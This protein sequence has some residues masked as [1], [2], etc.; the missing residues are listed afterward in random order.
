MADKLNTTIFTKITDT[1]KEI[2]AT[3]NDIKTNVINKAISFETEILNWFFPKNRLRALTSELPMRQTAALSVVEIKDAL[4][5]IKSNLNE[6]K[7]ILKSL[8]IVSQVQTAFNKYNSVIANGL[9]VLRNPINQVINQIK[10]LLDVAFINRV[11]QRIDETLE[12]VKDISLACVTQIKFDVEEVVQYFK[13][14]PSV[15]FDELNDAL[16]NQIDAG[17]NRL[18]AKVLSKVKPFNYGKSK[19]YPS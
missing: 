1:K 10:T 19:Y 11:E 3:M 13:D 15:I 7:M 8:N 2:I 16:K 5:S 9:K 18:L 12:E 17:L 4:N 14:Y 6:M